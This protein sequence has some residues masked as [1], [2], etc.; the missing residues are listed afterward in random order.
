MQTIYLPEPANIV[1]IEQMTAQEK[2]LTMEFADSRSLGHQPGQFVE[3]SV[4]GIGEAP[5]CVAGTWIQAPAT[6]AR[7]V[8]PEVDCRFRLQVDQLKSL[9]IADFRGVQNG[10]KFTDYVIIR[11][12]LAGLL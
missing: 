1:N 12:C 8:L 11:R 2:I 3:V 5:F 7:I 6:A 9:L 4:L 10:L